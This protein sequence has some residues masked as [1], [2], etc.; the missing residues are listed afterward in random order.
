[1][2]SAIY[3][4]MRRWSRRTLEAKQRSRLEKL[5]DDVS[6]DPHSYEPE[7]IPDRLFYSGDLD[8]PGSFKK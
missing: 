2:G 3:N 5:A 6:K 4:V 1:M 7:D 8:K